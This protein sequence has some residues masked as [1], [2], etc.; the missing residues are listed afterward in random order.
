MLNW[1]YKNP[2]VLLVLRQLPEGCELEGD[3]IGPQQR[4]CGSLL[5]SLNGHRRNINMTQR[6]PKDPSSR[7]PQSLQRNAPALDQKLLF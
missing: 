2:E 5:K 1:V 7:G 6:T 4:H 3:Y